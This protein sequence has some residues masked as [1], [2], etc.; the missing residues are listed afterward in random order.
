VEQLQIHLRPRPGGVAM[1][2]V[3][4]EVEIYTAP[5]LREAIVHAL[6]EGYTRLIVNLEG[7]QY[8]D[9][10]GLGALVGGRARARERGGNLVLICT[11]S[12]LLRLFDITGL[13]QLFAL[14]QTEEEALAI[15]GEGSEEQHGNTK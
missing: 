12:R 15:L 5:R 9:S 10:T 14:C 8:L 2:E 4:G 3:Q 6:E 7:V 1:L 13:N 11:Q